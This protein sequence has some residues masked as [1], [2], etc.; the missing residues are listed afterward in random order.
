MAMAV[1]II[2]KM[3]TQFLSWY[4]MKQNILLDVQLCCLLQDFTFFFSQ[5]VKR[6]KHQPK[7]LTIAYLNLSWA[8]NEGWCPFAEVLSVPNL[9]YLP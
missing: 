1:N 3:K 6:K 2:W 5:T 8:E 4:M 7:D 9:F